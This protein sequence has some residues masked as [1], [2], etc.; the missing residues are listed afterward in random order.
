MKRIYNNPTTKNKRQSLRR[1]QTDAE[2]LI[3]SRLRNKQLNG[4]K[5]YRQYSVDNY[6]LDFYCPKLKLGIEIDGGQHA[7][8]Q[9]Y[10]DKRTAYLKQQKNAIIRFWN[11]EVLDNLDGVI[12]VILKNITPPPPPLILR[13][14]AFLPE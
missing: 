10:D 6:V 2:R 5:F 7:E 3:W 1:N 14:G 11:N 13:G 9:Y 4:L 12:A 8:K